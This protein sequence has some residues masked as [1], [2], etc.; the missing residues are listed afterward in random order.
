[1][2]YPNPASDIACLSINGGFDR[3]VLYNALG[4][5]IGE[6]DPNPADRNTVELDLAHLAPGIYYVSVVDH[7]HPA[8]V[9][10][11]IKFN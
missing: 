1:M 2:I 6:Y 10:K 8:R 5:R 7:P 3:A 11:I 9:K 4:R